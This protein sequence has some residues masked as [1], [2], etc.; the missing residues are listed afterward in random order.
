MEL[1]RV[2]SRRV[3]ERRRP[4]TNVFDR[5]W[6]NLV[7]LDA[8]R[9]DVFR[10]S[11]FDDGTVG[12]CWSDG[13]NSEEFIEYSVRNGPLR[14]VVWVTANPWV[15]RYRDAIFKVVDVWD[16]GWDD[17]LETVPP[18]E[19]TAR[20]Q[21]AAAEYPHKRVVAHYMQPHYPFIGDSRR[22]LPDHA[23][24]TGGGV[25]ADRRSKQTIWEQLR[26]GTVSGEAVWNAYAENLEVTLPAVSRL[27][28]RLDGKS[29]VTADHGNAFGHRGFPVPVRVFGHPRGLRY[30]SLVKVPWVE[31]PA[32]ERRDIRAEK[33]RTGSEASGAIGQ[34]LESLGYVEG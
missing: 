4:R 5:D 11:S 6:D 18:E 15:S 27:V 29:V 28:D 30:E 31:F 3:L 20:A 25:R 2:F 21:T 33:I 1:N 34:R 13:S 14:D 22:Q 16:D 19:V 7:L 32:D 26:N 17:D 23:T 10:E 9:Y 24:F 8:C 12:W